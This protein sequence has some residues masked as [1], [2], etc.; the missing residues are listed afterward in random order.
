MRTSI[1]TAGAVAL[2][3]ALLATACSPTETERG[4]GRT[5]PV[6]LGDIKLVS[7]SGCDDMLAG[8]RTAAAKRVGPWGLAG[9]QIM[10]MESR[11]DVATARAKVPA[12][13]HS[14][15]NVHEAGV[16]EPDLVKTDG[17]RVIT[18]NRGVLRVVD[19]ATRKVTGTLKLVDAEQAWAPADLLVS[20]DRALVLFSGGGII[21]FG[22]MAKRPA[23]PGPRYV[24]VDLSGKP[25]VMG[26]FTPDG[27]HVD[28]RLV[29]STVRIVVRSQPRIDFPDHGPDVSEN[30]RTRRNADIIKKAPIEAW[31]PTFETA[32]AKGATSTGSVKC[33]Q[34]SHPADYSGTSMLTVHSFDLSQGLAE[35]S[36]VSVAADGDTVYGT[37]SSLYVT[38]NPSW[39]WPRPIEPPVVDDAPTAPATEQAPQVEPVP[40]EPTVTVSPSPADSSAAPADPTPATSA[41]ATPASPTPADPTAGPADPTATATPAPADPTV[42]AT[43]PAEPPEETEVHRFDISAPGAPRYVASGKVPGRLL[44]QY[45][46]SEHEGYLRVATT[47][48]SGQNSSS[49]VYVLK[50]DTLAKVGEVGGLGDGERIYSVRFIG[51]VGYVVTFKQVDPLYTLDLRDP[52]APRKTGELKITGYSAYLHPAGDGRLIGLGQEASEKGRTLGTQVS[53]FDVSDPAAPRRLSQMF[54]K[55]SGSEAEWDPHAFLYWARTGTAV[56][57]LNTWNGT[58]QTNG[59]ALVL[60]IDDSAVT[61]V[62]TIVHPRPKAAGDA[63]VAAYEPGIRRS[64]VIGDSL[65]TVS[66]LGLKVNDLNG[67]ADQAWI[68]FE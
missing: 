23:S 39:W 3:A 32:D 17:N 18:V 10:Y 66:D 63:R 28:A 24:L 42:T 41:P 59:A 34:V 62:G 50:A 51:P 16:D 65:W 35:T 31:L 11:S 13:E 1:R 64:I 5:T 61:K 48:T 45:S 8:L 30:E 43:T 4:A 26:S 56:L 67:L 68:P 6:D 54:Q 27:S 60:K 49:A 53:L 40:T 52:A 25:E 19:A 21:P 14:T 15:T 9:P 37:D 20:G 33:E 47:S 58:E 12:P 44:N 22:A 57:P 2:A 7:Y 29:G 55:D 38:S 36:P 46:L